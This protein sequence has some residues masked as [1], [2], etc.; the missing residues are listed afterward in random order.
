MRILLRRNLNKPPTLP[1]G[2]AALNPPHATRRCRLLHYS[3]DPAA[4]LRSLSIHADAIT[5][6][7]DGA[8]RHGGEVIPLIAGD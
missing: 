2:R 3:V 5:P 4:N 6:A 8:S 7:E 1:S